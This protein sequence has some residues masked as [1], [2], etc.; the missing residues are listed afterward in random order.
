M[1]CHGVEEFRQL[2]QATEHCNITVQI[3]RLLREFSQ[4]RRKAGFS[5]F[6]NSVAVNLAAYQ[7]VSAMS[8]S[9]NIYEISFAKIRSVFFISIDKEKENFKSGW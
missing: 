8:R 7:P 9:D 6:V 1:R 5:A 2:G 4:N 3:D